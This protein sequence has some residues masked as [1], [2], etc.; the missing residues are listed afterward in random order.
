MKSALEGVLGDRRLIK[1]QTSVVMGGAA[2]AVKHYTENPGAALVLVETHEDAE[3]LFAALDELAQV[4]VEGTRVVIIG[5]HNDV[6]LYRALVRRGVSEYIP[7]PVAPDAFLETLAALIADAGAQKQGRLIVFFGAAGG[8]G[9]ST[10]AHNVAWS[11]ARLFKEDTAL[12]DLD[13]PFGTVALDFNVESQQNVALAL[14]QSQR[15]DDTILERFMAKHGDNLL[16]FTAPATLAN[17]SDVDPAA[18]ESVLAVVRR[19]APFVALDLPRYWSAWTQKAL[20]QADEIVVTALPTLACLRD[21]KNFNDALTPKRTHDAPI[22]LVLNR[23]GAHAKTEMPAKEF[24]TAMGRPPAAII[25]NDG[26]AFGAAANNGQ[27][28]GEAA[29]NHKT[30]AIFDALATAL[31]ARKPAAAKR[32]AAKGG[33]AGLLGRKKA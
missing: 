4:C 6:Q 20:E 27:V 30:V 32:E 26:A 9:S 7:M 13:L 33:L 10:V 8:A 31:S 29:K 18:L 11:L 2:A 16:L 15:L 21:A 22:R 24:E 17:S 28:L 25:P 19:N 14:S 5:K 12:L 3:P 1:L 23:V